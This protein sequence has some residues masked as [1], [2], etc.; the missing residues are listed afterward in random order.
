MV[1]NTQNRNEHGNA[2]VIIFIAVALF[3]ALGAAFSSGSRQ[4][5]GLISDVQA[6]AYANQIISDFNEHKQSIK[7]LLIRGCKV[8]EIS[9]LGGGG[10]VYGG[11]GN[12]NAPNDNSCHVYEIKGAGLKYPKPP[13]GALSSPYSGAINYH[14]YWHSR[15]LTLSGG[16]GQWNNY[17]LTPYL[18]EEVCKKINEKTYG[19]SDIPLHS[20]T[21]SIG[22]LGSTWTSG[23]SVSCPGSFHG[24]DQC[25]DG[26]TGCLQMGTFLSETN[27]NVG[28]SL[29]MR[30]PP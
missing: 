11:Y 8:S 22:S 9:Y 15:N 25:T 27:V 28:F 24:A 5:T 19:V 23:G 21:P 20:G 29:M 7:R 26:P 14:R 2:L 6:E 18:S 30:N 16:S 17:M 12:I 4:S 13:L 1:M 3:A 10:G